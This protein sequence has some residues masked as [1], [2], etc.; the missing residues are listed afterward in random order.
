MKKK[1][2]LSLIIA[3]MCAISVQTMAEN[4]TIRFKAPADWTTVYFYIWGT[5]NSL[6]GDWPGTAVTKDTDGFFTHT[7]D[8]TGITQA[9]GIFN[10]N[11]GQQTASADVLTSSC[12]EAKVFTGTEYSVVA[13]TC[14]NVTS[15]PVN[16]GFKAPSTWTEVYFYI[17]GT[18][19]SLVGAWPGTKLTL[20]AGGFY[21]GSF[22]KTG[23][24]V[25]N[26]IFNNNTGEQTASVDVLA[27]GCWETTILTGTEYAVAAATC[28]ATGIVNLEQELISV[29]PNPTTD[30][31]AFKSDLSIEKVAVYNSLGK[32]LNQITFIENKVD[33]S[34]IPSGIYFLSISTKDGKNFFKNVMKL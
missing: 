27:G 17:W 15:I 4:V 2:T 1:I 3:F 16:V 24:A 31:L 29:Y 7:Y 18:N 20:G 8:N 23:I 21:T 26:G 9:M 28:P 12:W 13:V 25:A 5:N 22:D 10:N 14:P 19:N 6:L 33:L 11:A 32:Q 30:V 34:G